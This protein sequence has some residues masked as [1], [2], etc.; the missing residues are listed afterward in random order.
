MTS[1]PPR[2][3]VTPEAVVLEF[4]TASVGSRSIAILLDVLVQGFA[5]WLLALALALG[6][7]AAGGTVV[8]IAILILA[9]LIL[10]G[11][12]AAMETLWNGR[13]LG[14]AALGLRVVTRE[15][16]PIR[17]RHAAIR[18][19][20]GLVDFF[21][22]FG[23]VAVLTVLLTKRNQRLGDLVAG[24]IVLR[25]RTA[26]DRTVSVAF[27]PP[28]GYEGYVASLD[29]SVLKPDQ[30]AVIRSFLMRVFELT[31]PARMSI[32]VRLANPTA[33]AMHHQPPQTVGPEIFLACVAAAYQQRHAAVPRPSPF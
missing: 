13:T 11:Y 19:I 18:T 20:F 4:E 15:G 28:R 27:P 9:F 1:T 22:L 5:F 25:E 29:V 16:A 17:F 32:A 7:Q 24:T 2:G 33:I 10:F 8:T 26:A 12:P 3:I 21:L 30:Y 31:P 23:S 14:K 6:G